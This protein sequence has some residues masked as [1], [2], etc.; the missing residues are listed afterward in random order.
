[1]SAMTEADLDHFERTLEA[2]ALELKCSD[3]QMFNLIAVHQGCLAAER[4]ACAKVAE[5]NRALYPEDTPKVIAELIR[6]R[7]NP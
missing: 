2:L 6:A 7:N 3:M 1:M 5:T 4:E